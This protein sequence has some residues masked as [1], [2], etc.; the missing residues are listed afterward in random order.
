MINIYIVN[1]K[2]RYQLKA[3]ASLL[4]QHSPISITDSVVG[5]EERFKLLISFLSSDQSKPASDY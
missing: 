1:Y 3:T 5:L 2:T 4:S